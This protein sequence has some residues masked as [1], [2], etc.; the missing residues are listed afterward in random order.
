MS[1]I[2]PVHDLESVEMPMRRATDKDP[3]VSL[4]VI[5]LMDKKMDAH[6]AEVQ[7][8]LSTHTNEEMERYREIIEGNAELRDALTSHIENS[9]HR[10]NILSQSFHEYAE[11][12]ENFCKQ[13]AQAFPKDDEG[14]PD[15]R[16][17]GKAHESWMESAPSD[18]E[19]M[20]YVKAQKAKDEESSADFKFYRRAAVVAVLGPL[21]IWAAT[22]LYHAAVPQAAPA[23]P[24]DKEQAK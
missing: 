10:H 4:H 12:M 17:H 15:F 19:L 20:E 16:G 11:R 18:K 3:T 1:A 2:E 5:K 14:K 8:M 23:T 6:A 24:V 13:I 21:S 7:K 9:E 22:T